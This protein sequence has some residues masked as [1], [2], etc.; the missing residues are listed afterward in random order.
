MGVGAHLLPH[1]KLADLGFNTLIAIQSS[2][3]LMTMARKN[4]IHWK[5]YM[6]GYAGALLVS[7]IYMFTVYDYRF[8]LGCAAVFLGRMYGVSK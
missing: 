1:D 2:A 7:Y 3:F 5:T 6:G 4:I 8:L